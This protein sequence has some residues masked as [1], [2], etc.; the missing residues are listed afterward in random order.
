MSEL[1]IICLAVVVPVSLILQVILKNQILKQ[2][3]ELFEVPSNKVKRSIK[4]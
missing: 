1:A 3:N 2:N 4:S